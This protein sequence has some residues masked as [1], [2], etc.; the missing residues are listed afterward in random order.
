MGVVWRAT[1]T[2]LGRDAAIKFLKFVTTQDAM[3]L[4]LH[5][6]G[7]LPARVA[8]AAKEGNRNDPKYGPFIRGLDYAHA[9]D[10]VDAL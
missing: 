4:W 6:V 1:D 8:A 2:S 3:E 7:E 10:F 9:T 5:T